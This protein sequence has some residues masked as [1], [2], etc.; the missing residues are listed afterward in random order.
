MR[1]RT[2]LLGLCLLLGCNRDG[3]SKEKPAATKAPSSATPA[4]ASSTDAG[5]QAAALQAADAGVA[6][7]ATRGDSGVQLEFVGTVRG[8]VKLAK[9]VELPVTAPPM[10]AG[11][12][13]PATTMEPCPPID[14]ADQRP[15]SRAL[16]SGGL[17]PI[18]VAITGMRAVP[19]R[20]PMVQEIFI[21]ACRLQP[22]LIGVRRGDTIRVTNRTDAPFLP[23]LPGDKFMRGM[24]RGESR[25]FPAQ[26]KGSLT[27][28]CDMGYFCG[29]STI[30][31]L[32]H[33]LQAVTD[34][35]GRFNIEQVPLDEELQIHA[36]HPLFEVAS[37]P[38][39]L[40]HAQREKTLELAIT[41]TAAALATTKL[42]KGAKAGK[43][44][45]PK[46]GEPQ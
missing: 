35:Q 20:A 8:I 26:S 43:I 40:T 36:W 42:Q 18:H 6:Q 28:H 29:E 32:S 15:V 39:K 5:A 31:T 21:D 19:E 9:G 38:F 24:M 10:M 13:V 2:L 41:P 22:A 1:N 37:A 17:S 30:V 45:P 46:P 34:A 33:P 11:G 14:A 23:I 16:P 27:I 4:V 12:T 3:K 25:D 7:P 44:K